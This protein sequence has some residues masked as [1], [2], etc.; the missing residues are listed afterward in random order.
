[1]FRQIA[2]FFA[3]KVFKFSLEGVFPNDPKFVIAVVPHTS[4]WDFFVAIGVR[5]F[6]K[7]PIH[8]VGKKELFTPL[9]SRFFKNLGGMPLN[10]KKNENVVEAITRM[11]GEE[12]VFRMAIAP[13]GTRKKVSEWKTG[14]YYIAKNAGVPIL[15]IAL[16][17][18]N[19]LMKFHPL[20]TPTEDKE[21]DFS[22]LENLFKGVVG[23]I[24]KYTR[25]IH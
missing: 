9:T 24:P 19:R 25:T 17:W 1:M 12:E 23:K 22:Y 7:E 6:L 13:E 21:K 20:F 16:D 3:F 10:R 15:P 5:T 2:K 4:N 14:F 8:F 18:K 11:Y